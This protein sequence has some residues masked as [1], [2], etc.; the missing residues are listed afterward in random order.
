MIS[1][2]L[3]SYSIVVTSI[4]ILANIV[5]LSLYKQGDLPPNK[6]FMDLWGFSENI[7]ALFGFIVFTLFFSY[8]LSLAFYIFGL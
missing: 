6:D 1:K 2:I 3:F 5:N 8:P 4:I 7:Q